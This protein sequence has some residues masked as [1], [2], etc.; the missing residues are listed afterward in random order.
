MQPIPTAWPS[1]RGGGQASSLRAQKHGCPNFP[2]DFAPQI[3][4]GNAAV[5]RFGGGAV[6]LGGGVVGVVAGGFVPQFV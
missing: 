6:G 5:I 1:I 3:G 2:F 4:D